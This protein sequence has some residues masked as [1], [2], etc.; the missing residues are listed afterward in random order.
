ME[1]WIKLH[2][3]IVEHEIWNDVTTF[4]LF[5]LLLLKA[6]YHDIN[7]KGIHIKKG[8]YIRSYSKLA[9][10]LS[11]KEGRGVKKY[12]KHTI[13]KS[14]KKLI[15]S[16]MVTVQETE[17]GTLFNIV[18]YD[19]YQRIEDIKKDEVGTEQVTKWERTRNELGTNWEQEKEYKELKE[20]KNINFVIDNSEPQENEK[21]P[22]AFQFYEQN[23][24][25]LI[26]SFI[27][28]KINSWIDDLSDELVIEAM[29]IAIQN[30]AINWNY[31]ES[32]LRN[33]KQKNIKTLGDVEADRKHF[34]A[35]KNRKK[36]AGQQEPIPE[37]FYKRNQQNAQQE[38]SRTIDFEA[39]K[40]K[41]LAKLNGG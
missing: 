8:Q 11:Y 35:T 27:A 19:E 12:S 18:N 39:E 23:G 5:M 22:N 24:F 10:D 20:L 37:W 31:V 16:G 21:S 36:T 17:L 2:R 38:D 9:E 33:W 29:K 34:Q 6:S 40:Q 25:G 28:D 32:I 30:N 1:G 41:I 7:Y 4:R 15:E 14:V 13:Y 26:S 3:K